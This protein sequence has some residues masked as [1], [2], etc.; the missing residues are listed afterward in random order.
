MTV[1]PDLL[2]KNRKEKKIYNGL[3]GKQKFLS[4]PGFPT[5]P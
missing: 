3:T 1:R 2:K 4:W 5:D